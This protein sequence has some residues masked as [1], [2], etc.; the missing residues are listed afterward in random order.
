MSLK[1]TVW[2]SNPWISAIAGLIWER[3]DVEKIYDVE[4]KWPSTNNGIS[5]VA[6]RNL[7]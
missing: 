3:V 5:Q 7:K 1:V 2:G 6:K 4:I